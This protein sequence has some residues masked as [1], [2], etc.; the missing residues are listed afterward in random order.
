MFDKE[1]Y[2]QELADGLRELADEARSIAAS[3]HNRIRHLLQPGESMPPADNSLRTDAGRNEATA[4]MLA[5]MDR[6]E[7]ARK[8]AE[9]EALREMAEPM[10]AEAAS[11]IR[12]LKE[13][14]HV[15]PDELEAGFRTY[16]DNWSAYRELSAITLRGATDDTSPASAKALYTHP[17][18]GATEYIDEE[19]REAQSLV[20]CCIKGRSVDPDDMLLRLSF[21][22]YASRTFG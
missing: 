2:S 21:A 15:S 3:D 5:A 12:S 18:E 17:L 1:S 11:Y 22:G 4:A 19:A 10:S 16:G 8:R 14:D 7:V 9:A 6:I 13:R 20:R